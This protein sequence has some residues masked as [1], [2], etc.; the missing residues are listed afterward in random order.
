MANENGNG[1]NG[2]GDE[3]QQRQFVKYTFFAVNQTWLGLEPEFREAHKRALVE[4]VEPFTDRMLIRSYTTVGM[5]G[6]VDFLLWQ[7]AQELE[8]FQR[9]ETAI[10]STPMAPYLT[11]PRS[12]LATQRRSP[13][14]IDADEPTR[15]TVKPGEAKYFFLYPFVKTHEWYQLP[16]EERQA[17]MSGHIAKGRKYPNIKINTTYSFGLDDPE[18]VV[19]F[20]TDDPH[21]FVDLVMDLREDRGRPYTKLDTPI[22]SCIRM[23]LP[24]VLDTLGGIGAQQPASTQLTPQAESEWVQ[25][26]KVSDFNADGSKLVYLAGEPV[27]LFRKDESFFATGNV[28]SHARGPLCEGELSATEPKVRCPWHAAYF[29]LRT[30]EGTRPAQRP[31]PVYGTRVEGDAVLVTKQPLTEEQIEARKRRLAIA[32]E[33]RQK[34]QEEREDEPVELD[35]TDKELLNLI[36]WNFPHHRAPW[37][38]LGEKLGVDAE[39]VMERVDRLRAEGVIRQIAVIMDTRKLGYT[40]SLVAMRV[41]EARVPEAAELLNRHPGVSHNYRRTH[42]FNIWFTLAVPPGEELDEHL[43]ILSR[44]VQAEKVRKL[45]TL[46]L[47]KIG[48]K[49]D[50][51]RDETTLHKTRGKDDEQAIVTDTHGKPAEQRRPVTERDRAFV[52]E[53]QKD[54]PT[55]RFPFDPIAARLGVTV[56]ELFDWMRDMQQEG[57]LRRFAAILRH[58]RAGFTANGMAVWKVPEEIVDE[59]GPR[60]AAYPQVSH[61]YRR[62]VYPDWQ[63]NLFSMIHARSVE[64]CEQ[65]ASDM[66]ADFGFGDEDFTILYST[67]EFKK[68]RVAYFVESDWKAEAL[69]ELAAREAQPA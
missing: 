30:G 6:E 26:A 64:A 40:S 63:Y 13:Y 41:P 36:Q 1:R 45:P 8:M 16:F 9:L 50:M 3:P 53:L 65:I 24:A 52:R 59:I 34:T 46:K 7:V 68:T 48:V 69:K 56:E 51:N 18:F 17:M 38:A 4:A 57:Y 14:T 37:D 55:T 54:L 35:A 20:E 32:A 28:C 33:A 19:G 31:V 49:L 21:D 23:D 29:D 12:Y 15:T 47:Y 10:F 61:C 25:V 22:F 43:D 60:A 27:A 11:T 67:E 39:D 44:L 58:Q 42:E 2:A 5:R 66:A 62:P